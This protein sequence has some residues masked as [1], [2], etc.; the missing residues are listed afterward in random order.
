[1]IDLDTRIYKHTYHIVAMVQ[2]V[3]HQVHDQQ[4][5][6]EG[7]RMIV[8]HLSPLM[9]YIS[10]DD[11]EQAAIKFHGRSVDQRLQDIQACDSIKTYLGTLNIYFQ[12]CDPKYMCDPYKGPMQI[13]ITHMVQD[14]TIYYC[15]QRKDGKLK[16]VT[17][18]FKKAM[19]VF[20][21]PE[22]LLLFQ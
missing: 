17:S 13:E 4:S 20:S 10:T 11:I 14:K 15:P 2:T 8:D 9:P 12:P 1:M 3:T 22:A 6:H 21:K 5:L 19:E 18:D 7:M 16:I